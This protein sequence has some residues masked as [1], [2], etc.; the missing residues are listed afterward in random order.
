M[1]LLD[2]AAGWELLILASWGT[3]MC[4]GSSVVTAP[5]LSPTPRGSF[6]FFPSTPG[7]PQADLGREE[8]WRRKEAF[9]H[10]RVSDEAQLEVNT[11]FPRPTPARPASSSQAS[12]HRQAGSTSC[13]CH[14]GTDKQACLGTRGLSDLPCGLPGSQLGQQACF[15]PRLFAQSKHKH[16]PL[17]PGG[18]SSGHGTKDSGKKTFHGASS[19]LV[20]VQKGSIYIR[21]QHRHGY[22]AGV[23]CCF[24][25]TQTMGTWQKQRERRKKPSVKQVMQ[26]GRD[27]GWAEWACAPIR[28]PLLGPK[29]LPAQR[30]HQAA[31][32][33]PS[34]FPHHQLLMAGSQVWLCM[35]TR[36]EMLLHFPDP[37]MGWLPGRVGSA[38]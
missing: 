19:P 31:I 10:R 4:Q 8:V 14:H 28:Q 13:G 26:E 27:T 24:S 7:K 18:T 29:A 22:W 5:W 2:P 35:A 12:T 9:T 33:L 20:G 1:A 11:F 34:H 3:R 36:P 23:I 37:C 15:S 25:R 6:S 21:L 17:W 32:S 38:R 16:L 30:T